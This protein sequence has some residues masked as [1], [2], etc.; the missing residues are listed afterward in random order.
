MQFGGL[1]GYAVQLHVFRQ[2]PNQRRKLQFFQD[3][4]DF[5]QIGIV[6]ISHI[7]IQFDGCF[8]PDAR[9]FFGHVGVFFAGGQ[10]SRDFGV[11][12]IDI[13]IDFI[14][15]A[16]FLQQSQRRLFADAVNTGQIV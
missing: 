9:Q 14:K 6:D 7:P 4:G 10:L 16:V 2:A 13:G 1:F 12:F 5:F 15:R 11:D 3:F 8:D